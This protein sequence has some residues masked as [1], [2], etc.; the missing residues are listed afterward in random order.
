MVPDDMV[1]GN[2][3]RLAVFLPNWIGD[4]AMA[5]PALRAL[6]AWGRGHVSIIGVM[7][8]YIRD[9][10]E[11]TEWLDESI[12][13]EKSKAGRAQLVARLRSMSID[14]ALLLT[15]S[16]GTAWM[17][18][19]ARIPRRIGFAGDGRRWLLSEP[20]TRTRVRRRRL[21]RSAVDDYLDL[22]RTLGATPESAHIELATTAAERQRA[23]QVCASL[24]LG[25]RPV[26]AFHPGAAYGAAKCWP[27]AHFAT[28]ADIVA[29]SL[30]VDILVLCGPGEMELAREIKRQARTDRLD[31]LAET[32]PSIGLTKALLARSDLLVTT[33]SGP[34]HLAAGLNVP[35]VA[36][37]GPTDPRWSTN[38][39]RLE[40]RVSIDLDCRPCAA[41]T[42]PLGHHRCMTELP[43]SRVARAVAD[44]WEETEEQRARQKVIPCPVPP[45]KAGGRQGVG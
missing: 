13:Y 20:V 12:E 28:L 27:A 22:T 14:T 32:T 19:R 16:F 17:A 33:D 3:K 8:P 24:R 26:I 44:L 34:R 29:D 36:I 30:D 43:P 4:A 23:E 18:W 15:N 25:G 45:A 41:R 6:A 11:G 10:L 31:T 7:R 35:T 37:F 38:Y 5:T 40:R 1:Q 39:H 21:P 9:V 42:C 2:R